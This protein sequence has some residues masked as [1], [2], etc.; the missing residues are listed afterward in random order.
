MSNPSSN[1]IE[2]MPTWSEPPSPVPGW[3]LIGST[4]LG[5][6]L[7]GMLGVFLPQQVPIHFDIQGNPDGFS[8]R[9]TYIL[10]MSLLLAGNLVFFLTMPWLVRRTPDS[11]INFPDKEYWLAP[12]RRAATMSRIQSLLFNVGTATGLLFTLIFFL[13]WR[14]GMGYAKSINPWF[15][16]ALSLYL[17]FVFGS[18]YK[19][20]NRK[21]EVT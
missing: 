8:D 21:R 3:L 16:V 13:G 1:P 7:I 20:I 17:A 12:E 5:A 11:L 9:N 19:E 18:C 6:A 15:W 14:V 4:I 10:L 2:P